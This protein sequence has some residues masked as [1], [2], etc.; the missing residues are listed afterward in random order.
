VLDGDAFAYYQEAIRD[1]SK[2]LGREA[3][4]AAALAQHQEVV[5]EQCA[6][7]REVVGE[8]TLTLSVAYAP[9][10]FGLLAPGHL[11]EGSYTPYTTSRLYSLCRV[12]PGAE[13]REL[14]RDTAWAELSLET[15]PEIR[16]D[17]LIVFLG[18]GGRSYLEAFTTHPLWNRIKAVQEGNA[19][20]IE[21]F[22][23]TASYFGVLEGLEQ[24]AD[25]M[26][27]ESE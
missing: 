15:L 5:G 27:G 11:T 13:V 12:Q 18:R 17:H 26:T 19:F 16:A 14:A 22:I 25:V 6:R 1:V 21:D 9:R 3:Q 24:V 4:A 20:I 10:Y 23:D 8:G 2:V 7:I